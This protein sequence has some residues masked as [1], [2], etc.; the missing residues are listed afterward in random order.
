MVFGDGYVG[1]KV[2]VMQLNYQDVQTMDTLISALG[3]GDNGEQVANSLMVQ[4][5]MTSN[6]DTS[7]TEA[8]LN[9]AFG[10]GKKLQVFDRRFNDNSDLKN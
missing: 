3:G 9:C 5:A 4:A 8:V 6:F 7:V 2:C 10:T 1:N